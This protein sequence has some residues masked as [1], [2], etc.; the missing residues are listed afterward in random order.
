MPVS[1]VIKLAIAE[2]SSA[3]LCTLVAPWGLI[4]V[5]SGVLRIAWHCNALVVRL[6]LVSDKKSSFWP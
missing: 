3:A 4:A 2:I 6:G 5:L 1:A